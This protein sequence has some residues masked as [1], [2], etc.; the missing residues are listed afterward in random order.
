[1]IYILQCVY[2]FF[3][4]FPQLS[5]PQS[6][7]P[8]HGHNTPFLDKKIRSAKDITKTTGKKFRVKI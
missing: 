2:L 4:F 8:K 3:I 7:Y 6:D 1:M 5:F